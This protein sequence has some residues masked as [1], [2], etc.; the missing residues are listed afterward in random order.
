MAPGES[1][2]FRLRLAALAAL[3]AA[4]TVGAA[5]AT[6][7]SPVELLAFK[8]VADTHVSSARPR[9]NFGRARI[10][11]VDGSPLT[12]AYLRFSLKPQ[13][14]V[15]IASVTLLLHSGTAGR[16]L[17]AVRRVHQAD[18]RERRLTYTNAP[19]PSTR[20]AS[21]TPIRRGVWSAVDVTPFVG[22][23]DRDIT[24]AITTRAA[25]ELLFGSRESGHGPML[26][27]RFEPEDL[28]AE[29]VHGATHDG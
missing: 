14:H 23:L 1:N 22:D 25:R 15:R 4:T 28:I 18:W 12:T 20:Y 26:V 2:R 19:R 24:F 6:P 10:L 17:Y 13:H 29:P 16:A 7:P 8:A 5:G 9:E 3:A 21:S 11:R 27:V